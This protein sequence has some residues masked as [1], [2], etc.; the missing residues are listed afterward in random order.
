MKLNMSQIIIIVHEKVSIFSDHFKSKKKSNKPF[1]LF[2]YLAEKPSPPNQGFWRL[3]YAKN[4]DSEGWVAV[5]LIFF[6]YKYL[7]LKRVKL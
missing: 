1:I 2:N 3:R 4:L 5:L 6:I 7:F